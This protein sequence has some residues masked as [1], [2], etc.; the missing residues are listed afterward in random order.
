M[1]VTKGNNEYKYQETFVKLFHFSIE[2]M[3][4][5]LNDWIKNNE[6]KNEIVDIKFTSDCQANAMVMVVCKHPLVN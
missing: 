4:K 2:D 3:E 6:E 1:A 5:E